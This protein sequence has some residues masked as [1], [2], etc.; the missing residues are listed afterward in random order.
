MGNKDKC[1][2]GCRASREAML[3]SYIVLINL[4]IECSMVMVPH[5]HFFEF[6]HRENAT[7]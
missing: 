6:E 4:L 3:L 2:Y 1:P 7:R 5:I